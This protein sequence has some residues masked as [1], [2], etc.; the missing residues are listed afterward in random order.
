MAV[1]RQSLVS[2]GY[3]LLI[4]PLINEVANV[5]KQ[6][7]LEHNKEMIEIETEVEALD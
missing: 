6:N 4:I 2:C 5:L 3:L 7:I 1:I